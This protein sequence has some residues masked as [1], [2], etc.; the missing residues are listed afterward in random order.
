MDSLS[1]PRLYTQKDRDRLPDDW[2]VELVEG[3][4]VMAPSPVPWHQV[5]VKRLLQALC[6][7]LGP[8]EEERVLPAPLD[9]RIDPH[10]VYQPD[11]MVLPEGVRPTGIDWVIPAPIW[12][13][14]V[15]S[16]Y[17]GSHDLKK[18]PFY[19]RHGIREAWLIYPTEESIETHELASGL[20]EGHARGETVRS[21]A[22]PGFA[23]ELE[24]FFRT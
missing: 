24:R 20:I 6:A 18:L 5:L 10:N 2:R 19:A 15:I 17:T 13:A 23:L 14:E 7:H 9:V 16:P 1:L 4:L 3:E 22:V 12:V 21:R 11:L 8:G